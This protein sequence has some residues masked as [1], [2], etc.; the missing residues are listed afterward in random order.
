MW[1]KIDDYD[2][3]ININGEV[4]NN[5][6]GKILKGW[7]NRKGYYKVGLSKNDKRKI[8][9][10]HRLLYKYFKD[11]YQEELDID[12][13]DKN[14]KNNNLENLRMVNNQQN[15]CNRTKQKNCSSIYKG[16]HFDKSRNKWQ[17]YIYINY[18]KIQLG[19]YQTQEEAAKAYNDYID[20][21]NL[22]Y[23]SKNEI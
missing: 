4:R 23:Y 11:D 2:Y 15:S 6:T 3:S 22:T 14:R 8:F 21:N 7:I 12:H 16:V 13:I 18:K 17:S 9:T 10:I 1:K 19:C 20:E 5:K